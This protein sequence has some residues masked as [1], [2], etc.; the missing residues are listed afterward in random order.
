MDTPKKT[1][2]IWLEIPES[3]KLYILDEKYE[4]LAKNAHQQFINSGDEN[5]AIFEI[6]DLLTALK[7][8]AEESPLTITEPMQIVIAGFIL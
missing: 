5:K 8:V 6:N 7:P 2:L 4:E 1:L 3:S